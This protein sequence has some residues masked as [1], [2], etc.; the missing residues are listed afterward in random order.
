M[1]NLSPPIGVVNLAP[2]V[3]VVNLDPPVGVVNLS[4]P[5]GVVNLSPPIAHLRLGTKPFELNV[6]TH[7]ANSVINHSDIKCD[8][9]R[10]FVVQQ[11]KTSNQT[12]SK[13]FVSTALHRS[14]KDQ[15]F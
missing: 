12:N 2:P 10:I 13:I 11:D 1:V 5:V 7:V 4:P 15:V 6:E 14:Q 8:I 3:G 9:I